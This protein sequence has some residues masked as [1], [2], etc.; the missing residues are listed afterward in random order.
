ME[1]NGEEEGKL[2][3]TG[4]GH[5]QQGA[6]RFCYSHVLGGIGVQF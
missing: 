1:G 3:S 4:K 5:V 6:L 2:G